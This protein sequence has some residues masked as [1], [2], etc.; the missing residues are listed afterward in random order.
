MVNRGH[1]RFDAKP[2]NTVVWGL[3]RIGNARHQEVCD[4]LHLPV[5]FALPRQG[6]DQAGAWSRERKFSILKL[7]PAPPPTRSPGRRLVSRR[8]DRAGCAGVRRA[9]CA[10]APPAGWP[11]TPAARLPTNRSGT[12][13]H[14]KRQRPPAMLAGFRGRR[15]DGQRVDGVQRGGFSPDTTRSRKYFPS[16][17]NTMRF[18][19][20]FQYP[21]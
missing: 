13:P 10:G 19:E 14:F 3:R 11:E 21:K 2:L 1:F 4:V 18:R 12:P 17:S 7:T 6:R 9:R 5:E 16:S 20:G 15:E 8:R